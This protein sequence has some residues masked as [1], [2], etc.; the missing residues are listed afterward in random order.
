MALQTFLLYPFFH[1]YN[2]EL[3][4]RPT[5]PQGVPFTAYPHLMSCY[6]L[7]LTT[8]ALDNCVNFNLKEQ[9]Q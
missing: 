5:T 6:S 7:L 9:S 1:V 3:C 8:A 4:R 2:Y